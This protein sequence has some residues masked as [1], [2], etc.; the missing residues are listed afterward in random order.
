MS[1][2][3]L[4]VLQSTPPEAPAL[5]PVVAL[6]TAGAITGLSAGIFAAFQVAILPALKDVDDD[7]FVATFQAVNRVIINPAF[8]AVFVGAPVLLGVA[9]ALW[10]RDDRPVAVWLG[11]ACALQ[12]AN[13]AITGRGNIPLNDALVQAGAVSGPAAAVA[14]VAFEAPWSRLHLIR[15]AASVASTV[16]VGIAAILAIRH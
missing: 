11:V 16:A 10:W 9:S 8:L 15:T 14:R 5:W 3:S 13:I 12:L 7:A 1:I 6:A 4:A 2:P